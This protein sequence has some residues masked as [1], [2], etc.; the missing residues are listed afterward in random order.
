MVPATA[1]I[2]AE[3]TGGSQQSPILDLLSARGI[4]QPLDKIVLIKNALSLM[5]STE[6]IE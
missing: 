2:E 6:L 4:A 1:L 5:R 3:I